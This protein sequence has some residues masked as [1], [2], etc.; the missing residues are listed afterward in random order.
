MTFSA[1]PPSAVTVESLRGAAL[2]APAF[3]IAGFSAA[4]SSAA[5]RT[6]RDGVPYEDGRQDPVAEDQQPGL[7]R[8]QPPQEQHGGGG[9]DGAAAAPGRDR[10]ALS[11]HHLCLSVCTLFYLGLLV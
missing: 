3:A 6:L 4:S 1:H 9:G 10:C 8:R 5:S 2:T 7:I 11:L